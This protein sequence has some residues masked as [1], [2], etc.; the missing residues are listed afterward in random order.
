LIAY[1]TLAELCLPARKTFLFPQVLFLHKEKGLMHS[2]K[3]AANAFERPEPT[4]GIT[5]AAPR[6]R[7]VKADFSSNATCMGILPLLKGPP[8][9]VAS[10]PFANNS[11]HVFA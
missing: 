7:V 3:A 6:I 8:L 9:A 11:A 1:L 5:A 4:S 10:A 2:S